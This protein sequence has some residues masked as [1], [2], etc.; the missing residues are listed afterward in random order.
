MT[1]KVYNSKGREY[2]SDGLGAGTNERIRDFF[3]ANVRVA[4]DLRRPEIAAFFRARE[5]A[6]GRSEQFYAVY[7]PNS[8]R[9]MFGEFMDELERTA[10]RLGLTLDT[11]ASEM[12]LVKNISSTSVA[13]I[14]DEFDL[15]AVDHLLK[16]GRRP[17]LGVNSERRAL[18]LLTAFLQDGNASSGA[19]S[20]Q[21]TADAL[22]DYD[23]VFEPD[24]R[25]DLVPLGDT[26]RLLSEAKR[27]MEDQLV[28]E[29]VRT[30]KS[31]VRELKQNTSMDAGEIR[32]RLQR[33]IPTL[34]S[35]RSSGGGGGGG[36]DLDTGSLDT[37]S[38]SKLSIGGFDVPP[39]AAAAVAVVVL[40][41][42]VVGGIMVSGVVSPA[43][44]QN[45][46]GAGGGNGPAIDAQ[47]DG[48]G[49]TI[50]VNGNING[51]VNPKTV[52][53]KIV[54]QSNETVEESAL[55]LTRAENATG[56][57]FRGT[58]P[59]TGDGAGTASY[60]DGTYRVTLTHENATADD[61]NVTL[62]SEGT[63]TSTPGTASTPAATSTPTSTPTPTPTSTPTPTP[64]PTPTSTPANGTATN[65]S[66]VIVPR[67]SA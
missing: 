64:T 22:G 30:I 7:R 16:N 2:T 18:S 32:S 23:V 36:I 51:T 41:A 5:S 29:K 40:A 58:F 54:N 65:S 13:D 11:N 49:N 6:S 31:D 53:V 35:P 67:A 15:R 42:I 25:R 48:K 33:E 14:D 27:Q 66:S 9:G 61:G 60:P 4:I 55:R 10:S 38:S 57:S 19:I 50:A 1:V 8:A 63:T 39:I 28:D 62:G 12:S 46:L 52:N 20:G 37:G 43:S 26:E 24:A 59:K 56:M 17:R 45:V 3:F 47:I 21:A 44:I 34:K